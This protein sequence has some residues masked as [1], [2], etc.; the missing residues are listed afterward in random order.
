MTAQGKR[1]EVQSGWPP[2]SAL[3]EIG[4]IGLGKLEAGDILHQRRPLGRLQPQFGHPDLD[5]LTGRAQPGQRERRTGSRDE[6][7]LGRWRQMKQQESGLFVAA[8]L[9]DQLIVIK[10]E[11][12]WCVKCGQ[13]LHQEGYHRAGDVRDRG[14]KRP[15]GII[16]VE[17]RA[18]SLQRVHDM[19]P[20]PPGVIV[21]A[22][23]T[24]PG[25]P[26]LF[27]QAGPPLRGESGLAEARRSLNED[28]PGGGGGQN[29]DE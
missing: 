18:G 17:A 29:G 11:N 3:E 16:D 4:Q 6:R 25:E 5:H 21:A 26:S 24:D 19:P 22:I 9:L 7:E 27:R 1:R 23:D 15:E 13:L 10:N 2:F 14:P 28:E 8:R 12:N 20:Q